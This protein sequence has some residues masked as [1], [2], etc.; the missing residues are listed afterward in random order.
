MVRCYS[1][2]H[3]CGPR[4]R[5]AGYIGHVASTSSSSASGVYVYH[6]KVIWST[7]GQ[8]YAGVSV[9]SDRVL[10]RSGTYVDLFA[11][12]ISLRIF[13]AGQVC[14]DWQSWGEYLGISSI[15]GQ[16][17][18]HSFAYILLSVCDSSLFELCCTSLCPQTAF[19]A[20]AA[21]LVISYA[22]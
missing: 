9:E 19:A 5:M 12:S 1:H 20:S 16:S 6:L 15:L 13:L 4:R 14:H 18:L 10:C 8:M 22:P 3:L 17:L 2:W 7:R 21:V 11:A